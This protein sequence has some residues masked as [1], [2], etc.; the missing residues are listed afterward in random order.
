MLEGETGLL[1]RRI[2]KR[3]HVPQSARLCGVARLR[4]LRVQSQA[5]GLLPRHEPVPGTAQRQLN[6]Q[7]GGEQNVNLA[8]FDFLEVPG[9]QT[10]LFRQLL[11]SQTL[12]HPFTAHVGAEDLDP[13]PFFSAQRH[14]IL[15]RFAGWKLN[16]TYI[17]K[18]VVEF[19]PRR[20]KTEATAVRRLNEPVPPTGSG[21][22]CLSKLLSKTR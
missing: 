13:R 2:R 5:V 1:I 14:D 19:Y 15:H 10:G 20:R 17:V 4:F 12:A 16:D 3:Q 9:G 7:G 11:L 8:P 21:E 18:I 22:Q 6:P